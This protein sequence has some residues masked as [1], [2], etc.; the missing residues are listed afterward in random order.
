MRDALTI[1]PGQKTLFV[2]GW[3]ASAMPVVLDSWAIM[4]LLDSD[5]PAAMKADYSMV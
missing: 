3:T 2:L 5:E 1:N 4:R